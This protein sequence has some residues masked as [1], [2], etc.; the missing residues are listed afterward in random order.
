M[1]LSEKAAYLKGL[2][3]GMALKEDDNTAK[4]FKAIIDML[5]DVALDVEDLEGVVDELSE[6][7]N[8][9]DEDLADVE[10]EVYGDD[11]CDCCDD[12]E[13]FEVTC[14]ECG[15]EFSVD[16]EILMDGSIECPNCGELLEFD[17]DE[18]CDCCC[19]DPDCESNKE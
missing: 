10:D 6:Q 3:E 13:F 1:T 8:E 9:I 12:D 2:A 19:D 5:D 7:V 15:E 18:D 14:P 11:E 17:I 4:L 16:E